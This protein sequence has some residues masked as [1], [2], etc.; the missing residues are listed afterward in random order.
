MSTTPT[1]QWLDELHSDG[2]HLDLPQLLRYR[3][4][5]HFLELAPKQ[6]IQSKLAGTYL[7]RSK[8]RGMEFDEV[9]HYQNGD[10]V[11]TIDWRVTARTGKVH[12]KLFRE[13][14]ERPVFVLTDLSN[15]MQMGSKLLFKAVQAAHLAAL[16]G[17]HAR[18]RGDKFGGVVFNEHSIREL[19]PAARHTGVLRYLQQ[20]QLVNQQ[21]ESTT[22][23]ITLADAL[24]QL[25]QLCRPGSLIYVI[26]D[27]QQTNSICWKHL[28]AMR[29]HNEIR[30]CH[31]VDPLDIKLPT[32]ATP[33]VA[34][35]DSLGIVDVDLADPQLHQRYAE[36][37]Q[38]IQHALQIH[39][40]G[41]GLSLQSITTAVPLAVQF[42]QHQAGYMDGGADGQR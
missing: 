18:E 20:L 9:R 2:V 28:Q 19:K 30:L 16:I 39:S 35:K 38:D 17:W 26:S 12:T 15:T 21:T 29:A 34:A 23:A 25:R 42:R 7:A 22:A 24:G 40:R 6:T 11:R 10:D 37:Q 4:Q 31:I 3:H 36:Q 33:R 32:T 8:G 13:E 1:S 5:T 14:K 27:F 41:M